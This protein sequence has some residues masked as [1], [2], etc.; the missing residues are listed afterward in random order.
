MAEQVL[1]LG[2]LL[3]SVC[4]ASRDDF[5][6]AVLDE[7]VDSQVA[8][9]LVALPDYRHGVE[10]RAFAVPLSQVALDVLEDF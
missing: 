8:S 3:F 4:A 1:F 10:G 9:P 2:P 6:V 5:F 7:A